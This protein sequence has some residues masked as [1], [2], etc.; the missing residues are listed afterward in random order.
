VLNSISKLVSGTD[1]AGAQ[2]SFEFKPLPAKDGAS[3]IQ[4]AGAGK[5]NLKSASQVYELTLNIVTKDGK[6]I[7]VTKFDQPLVIKLHVT[8]NLNKDLIGIYYIGDDGKL[9]YIGGTLEGDFMTAQI[10]HFSKY[11]VLEYD[12]SFE[13][14]KASYWASAV[15]KVLTA[16][17]IVTGITET[18]FMP[19]K[20][21]TRAE[22]AALLV[23]A[24]GIKAEGEAGYS[25][26][27]QNAW[28]AP[29]VAAASKQGIVKGGQNNTFRPN[30]TITREEMAV[31]II[32]AL[33]AKNGGKA[34]DAAKPS[35]FSDRAQVSAWAVQFVDAAAQLELVK[36]RA[37]RQFA[38]QGVMTRAESA[39]VI[40]NLLNK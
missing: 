18:K 39:Q 10:S 29:Y 20:S 30:D 26:I 14:V 38:P 19:E 32:R 9:E 4:A 36:G 11:A 27:G 40:Y 16:K 3:L 35:A 33:E 15:I 31:M 25:D 37:K 17:Q 6:K 1:A 24:L 28:Y 21:I 5:A 34:A 7:A 12:K 23:R 8:G 13:D 2:I 22:F